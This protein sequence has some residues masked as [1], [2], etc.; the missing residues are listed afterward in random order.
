[1]AMYSLSLKRV[2][3]HCQHPHPFVLISSSCPTSLERP[4]NFETGHSTLNLEKES[5]I[6]TEQKIYECKTNLEVIFNPTGDCFLYNADLNIQADSVAST[7]WW[8]AKGEA[9]HHLPY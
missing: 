1:V 8:G 4:I 2:A 7:P 3:A 6:T 9:N 5:R